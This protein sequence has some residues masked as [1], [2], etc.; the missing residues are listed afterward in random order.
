MVGFSW[1][2]VSR[3]RQKHC[4]ILVDVAVIVAGIAAT[5]IVV[6]VMAVVDAGVVGKQNVLLLIGCWFW[7]SHS[8]KIERK[9]V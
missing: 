7:W 9:C 3:N 6:V 2:D 5:V 4:A 1:V 8:K